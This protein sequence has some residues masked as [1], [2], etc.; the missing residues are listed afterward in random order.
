MTTS[1]VTD[2]SE[3]WVAVAEGRLSADEAALLRK[4]VESDE[5][6]AFHRA[7]TALPDVARRERLIAAMIHQLGAQDPGPLL[8]P[9]PRRSAA[10]AFSAIAVA[11]VAAVVLSWRTPP[12]PRSPRTVVF[13]LPVRNGL[14]TTLASEPATMPSR[15]FHPRDRVEFDIPVGEDPTKA[16]AY[17]VRPG[18]DTELRCEIA[19]AHGSCELPSGTA[20]EGRLWLCW[21]SDRCGLSM[22]LRVVPEE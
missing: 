1:E 3:I 8:A 10:W 6:I 16:R 17:W 5:D 21:P 19:G 18:E 11:A 2:G 4:G 12:L 15:S 9:R 22:L 14:T 20:G 7:L 13:N